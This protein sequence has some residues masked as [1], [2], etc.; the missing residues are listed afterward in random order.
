MA[1][2]Q[3]VLGIHIMLP[4]ELRVQCA[5]ISLILVQF[6][7][8]EGCSWCAYFK[9]L[10]PMMPLENA[11]W[12]MVFLNLVSG[13]LTFCLQWRMV[14]DCTL[15]FCN[16]ANLRTHAEIILKGYEPG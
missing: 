2:V 15:L 14:T 9:Q 4:L 13:L 12:F 3:E 11:L 16:L 5:E 10:I 8:N 7:V 1:E 6:S